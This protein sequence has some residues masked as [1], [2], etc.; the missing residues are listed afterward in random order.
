MRPYRDSIGKLTI[1]VGRN[2]ED[3]GIS[4]READTL[5]DNDL[6]EYSAAVVAR[7]PFA[8]RLDDARRGVLINLAF[9]MGVE[10]LLKFT[11][12]LALIEAGDYAGAADEM[13]RS[14]WAKQVGAR[15]QRLAEQTRTGEWQ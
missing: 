3:K 11:K 8:H 9:N 7:I 6:G 1:G 12:T 14:K 4:Q 15:A 13:L 10:G 5:L 2:L